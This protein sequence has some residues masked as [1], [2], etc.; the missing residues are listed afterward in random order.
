MMAASASP[1]G[2]AAAV[3]ASSTTANAVVA[4]LIS[5]RPASLRN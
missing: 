5:A 2:D 1:I 3:G 4:T